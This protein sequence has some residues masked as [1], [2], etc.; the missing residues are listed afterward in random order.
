MSALPDTQLFKPGYILFLSAL[1][2]HHSYQC[3][4]SPGM[5]NMRFGFCCLTLIAATKAAPTE[6]DVALSGRQ[7][8]AAS[9]RND[10]IDGNAAQCPRAI[11]IFA[12]ASGENGNI[13]RNSPSIVEMIA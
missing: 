5:F 9:T 2:D 1:L 8:G 6:R 3:L 10:L 11:F 12:R 4:P 13:V 7:F